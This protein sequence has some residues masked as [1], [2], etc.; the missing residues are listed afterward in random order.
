[1]TIWVQVKIEK[2]IHLCVCKKRTFFLCVAA[3]LISDHLQDM[4]S[5][6]PS[7]AWHKQPEIIIHPIFSQSVAATLSSM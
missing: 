1:M 2:T 7:L 3:T 5:T 6:V 4:E